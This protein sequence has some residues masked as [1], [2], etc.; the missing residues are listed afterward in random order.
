VERGEGVHFRPLHFSTLGPRRHGL[1]RNVAR[2]DNI[3]SFAVSVASAS[4]ASPDI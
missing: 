4:T 1:Q 2:R 3:T